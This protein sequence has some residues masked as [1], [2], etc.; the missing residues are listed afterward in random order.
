MSLINKSLEQIRQHWQGLNG[1]QRILFAAIAAVTIAGI[2]A[3]GWWSSRPEYIPLANNLSPTR[4]SE[5]K[6]ALDAKG[7]D[8]KMNFS[9][10]GILVPSGK[11]NE[12]KLLLGDEDGTPP[13]TNSQIPGIMDPKTAE[14]RIQ[15]EKERAVEATLRRFRAIESA[16]VQI[17]APESS[18]FLV[19]RKPTTASV[20]LAIRK[21]HNFTNEQAAGVASVVSRS[22]T[23]LVPENVTVSDTEG[24]IYGGG[25][26]ASTAIIDHQFDYRRR[27]EADLAGKAETML[28]NYLGYDKATVTVSADID[29]TETTR[30]DLKYDP[31]GKVKAKETI[32]NMK[33]TGAQAIAQGVAGVA[34][35]VTPAAQGGNGA[36][37][38][39]S[40]TDETIEAEFLNAKTEDTV[41]IAGGKILR[42]TV[43]AIIDPGVDAAADPQAAGAAGQPAGAAAQPA[44]DEAK[45]QSIIEQAVG[46]DADRGDK[47]EV[48][49]AK[50]AGI[51]PLDIPVAAPQ[52]WNTIL[53]VI[54]NASLGIA[55]IV[56]FLLG[57]KV[58]KTIKPIEV[59][60]RRSSESSGGRDHILAEL[61]QQAKENPELVSNILSSWLNSEAQADSPAEQPN[62][63][64]VRP[65]A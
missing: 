60:G 56:A 49:F 47:I 1:S 35:N 4:M 25:I 51:E 21:G 22:V 65:A 23:G 32:K 39:Q 7:I 13:A 19:E 17:A 54:E 64:V 59:E 9:G 46:F 61:S 37:A 63:K 53:T 14:A 41:R 58:I 57:M 48:L 43:A 24:R 27:L 50:L 20:V 6:T 55:A 2:S 16:S 31:S 30:V 33:T 40:T 11:W 44:I 42:L 12:A 8:N 26:G 15:Q 36:A 29:F 18:P 34:T 28:A 62:L 45:V 5:I 3:I 52:Y 10:E 38:P